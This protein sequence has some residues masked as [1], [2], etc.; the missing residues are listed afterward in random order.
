MAVQSN[1]FTGVENPYLKKSEWGWQVDPVGY[2]YFLNMLNDLYHVPLFDVEN[3][4]GAFDT[5]E[6]DGSIH[7]PY[8][9]DYFR[10]HVQAMQTALDWGVNLIGYTTWGCIDVVSAGTGEMRK[11]YGFI[12]VDMDDE[13]KGSMARS[14]KDSFYW[15]KKVIATNGADLSDDFEK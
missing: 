5:V 15:Y 13:G 12:Y 6:E 2:R 7:D 8:R 11:R 4:L 1:V 14:R 9:I 3:G 10:Q